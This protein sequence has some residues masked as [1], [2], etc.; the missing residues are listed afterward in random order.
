MISHEVEE[1]RQDEE[2]QEYLFF[3]IESRQDDGRHI[4]NLLIMQDEEGFEMMFKG[5]DCGNQFD[6]W[7]LASSSLPI[8]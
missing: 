5:D 8:T 3:D 1:G 6:T 2:G 7:L 4:A